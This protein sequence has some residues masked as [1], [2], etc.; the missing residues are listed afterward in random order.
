MLLKYL[1]LGLDSTSFIIRA[2]KGAYHIEKRWRVSPNYIV[3]DI[4]RCTHIL[5]GHTISRVEL[6]RCHLSAIVDTLRIFYSVDVTK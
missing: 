5:K 2:Q 6:E 1:V 4:V 3:Q